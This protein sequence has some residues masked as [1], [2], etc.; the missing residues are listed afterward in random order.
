MKQ[1]VLFICCC[2]SVLF[3]KVRPWYHAPSYYGKVTLVGGFQRPKFDAIIT[4]TVKTETRTFQRIYKLPNGGPFFSHNV[5]LFPGEN[6]FVAQNGIETDTLQIYT[7]PYPTYPLKVRLKWSGN[8]QDYDLHVNEIFYG[9]L[10]GEDGGLDHDW[11]RDG[12]PGGPIETVAY[13]DAPAG[14]YKIYVKYYADHTGDGEGECAVPTDVSVEWRGQ[15]LY[16]GK[17]TLSKV[18]SVWPIGTL[19]IHAGHEIGGLAVDNPKTGKGGICPHEQGKLRY[20]MDASYLSSY[21]YTSVKTPVPPNASLFLDMGEAAQFN[22]EGDVNIKPLKDT[23]S[24]VEILDCFGTSLGHGGTFIDRLLGVYQNTGNGVSTL[25]LQS[26]T[27]GEQEHKRLAQTEIHNVQWRRVML[28]DHNRDGEIEEDG[29]TATSDTAFEGDPILVWINDCSATGDYEKDTEDCVPEHLTFANYNNGHVDG[30][31]D[32]LNFTPVFLNLRKILDGLPSET[33]TYKLHHAESAVNVVWTA[34]SRYSCD[35]FYKSDDV[36]CGNN[37]DKRPYEAPVETVTESGIV[38]PSAFL[39]KIKSS[40]RYGVFMLEGR[41]AST[42]PLTLSVYAKSA[43]TKAIFTYEL[44]LNVVPIESM[45][46][47]VNLRSAIDNPNQ[48]ITL[49]PP[50]EHATTPQTSNKHV[51]FLHGYNVNEENARGWAAEIFKRLYRTGSKARFTAITWKGDES[52]VPLTDKTPNYYVNVINAFDTAPAL[53]SVLAQLPGE[54]TILAHSLG[55]MLAS[56]AIKSHPELVK[57]YVMLNAALPAEAFN[58]SSYAPEMI[59]SDWNGYLPKTYASNWYKLFTAENDGRK[60]LTWR[61]FFKPILDSNVNVYNF[62]S[63]TEDV[64]APVIA[65]E[66]VNYNGKSWVY[67][68]FNKGRWIQW[69]LPGRTACEGGWGKNR[70]WIG[71]SISAEDANKMTDEQLILTPVFTPFESRFHAIT[72]AVA[73]TQAERHRIL[74]DGIPALS[75]AVGATYIGIKNDYDMYQLL[76]RPSEDTSWPNKKEQWLHSDIRALAY[77]FSYRV[78]TRIVQSLNLEQHEENP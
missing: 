55:N 35:D 16:K 67:Q 32:L 2:A 45:Y 39:D 58:E 73:I 64:L 20:G 61:N 26:S 41:E 8:N 7:K 1:L 37:L 52:H 19:V 74:A 78:F 42:A 76:T 53:T 23:V 27:S 15:L 43:P 11:K 3:G 25:S 6:T 24:E 44:P 33:F 38:I 17:R 40:S 59:P 77:P 47:T 65:S 49:P 12:D 46:Q 10:E 68:E 9:N 56:A 29:T 18:G 51:L 22:A 57:N 62:Y 63:S 54:K 69:A 34:L 36:L 72:N 50:P 5:I 4:Q 60:T 75:H 13:A 21:R 66:E 28:G 14:T 31:Y 70:S 48:A 71:T 30:R